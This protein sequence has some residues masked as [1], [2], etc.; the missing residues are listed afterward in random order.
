MVSAR[1]RI[2]WLSP[3]STSALCEDASEA[4]EDFRCANYLHFL[5]PRID[6]YVDTSWYMLLGLMQ[7]RSCQ[8]SLPDA[9]RNFQ[10]VQNST[11]PCS[12]LSD[13]PCRPIMTRESIISGSP[14]AKEAAR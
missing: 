11:D 13:C 4:V 9:H 6:I 2:Q 8:N 1:S 5:Y 3:K 10:K 14:F 12:D 7:L